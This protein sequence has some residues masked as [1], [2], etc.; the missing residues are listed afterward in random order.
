MRIL[1]YDQSRYPFADLVR[2]IF[3]ISDLAQIQSSV[4]LERLTRGTDQSTDLHARFYANNA[5]VLAV[6]ETF[7]A[8]QI[9]PLYA[10]RFCYQR[11]PTFR[12]QLP[13]NVAVGDFHVDADYH[14]PAGE[15]NFW[16]PLTR[17]WGNNSIWIERHQGEGDYEPVTL[18]P[19]EVLAFDAV[20]LRHGNKL[21][22]TGA[23]RVSLDFRCIPLS[24][25]P[26]TATRSVSYGLPMTVDGYYKVFKVDVGQAEAAVMTSD[27]HE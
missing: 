11:V 20:H 16:L 26:L 7:V 13:N 8:D 5:S 25:L 6:Y 14:H 15:C 21:N 10:E 1:T 9:A 3:G 2:E 22:D 17:C 23:A 27:S 4:P 12:V 19:G 18:R 24:L